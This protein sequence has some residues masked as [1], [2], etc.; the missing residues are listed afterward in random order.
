VPGALVLV[1]IA[2]PPLLNTECNSC[3]SAPA[4]VCRSRMGIADRF[5]LVPAGWLGCGKSGLGNMLR[6]LNQPR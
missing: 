4:E 2:A 5:A 6:S 3:H 1:F